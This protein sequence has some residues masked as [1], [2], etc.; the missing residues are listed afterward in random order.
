[1]SGLTLTAT[2][3]LHGIALHVY[4]GVGFTSRITTLSAGLR[5]GRT[6]LPSTIGFCDALHLRSQIAF[7]SSPVRITGSIFTAH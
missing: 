6:Q 2:R 5:R 1:M 3:A 7:S 4:L